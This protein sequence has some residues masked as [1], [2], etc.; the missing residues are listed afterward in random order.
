MAQALTALQRIA[1]AQE[2]TPGTP[3]APNRLVPHIIGSGFTDM[4][5]RT[6]LDEARGVLARVDDPVVRRGSTL[7][8]QQELDWDLSLLALQC[9]IE[10]VTGAPTQVAGQDGT[11]YLYTF[12]ANPTAPAAKASATFEVLQSDGTNDHIRRQFSHARP[13][14]IA[15][16]FTDGNTTKLNTTWMGGAATAGVK[17][18][19]PATQLATRRVVPVA[20]WTVALDDSWGALGGSVAT[21]VRGIGW[22]LNTGIA[23]SYHLRGRET[24]DLDGWYDGRIEGT[25]TLTFDIDAAAAAEIAHWRAGDL[26]YVRLKADNGHNVAERPYR[27]IEI[28]QALRVV[29]SPNLLA[30]D[31][32]QATVALEGQIR[33]GAA[34]AN[35][36]FLRVVVASGLAEW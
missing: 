29:T 6:T 9:G 33:A 22:T 17:P 16:D 10:L 4:F 2:S 31:G 20:L 36:D 13:T 15:L 21:N 30:N 5:E 24:L 27:A 19:I 32:E 28:D 1:A 11:P 26:R 8:L 7:E 3:E 34:L 18:D 35:D 23:P 14:Q 25:L 12:E